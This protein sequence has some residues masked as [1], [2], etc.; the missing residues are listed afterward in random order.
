MLAILVCLFVLGLI[1]GSFISALTWRLHK[2][3]EVGSGQFKD[4]KSRNSE[5]SSRNYSMVNGRSQC[6]HCRHKLEAKDLVP[7][8]SWLW[9]SG[10]CRYCKKAISWQYPAIEVSLAAIFAGSYYFWPGGVDGVG[11]IILLSTW[12]A[13]SIGLM[14]LLVYDARWLL[15][16]NK[17]IYPTLAVA[18]SGRLIYIIGFED[19]KLAAFI[20]WALAVII[21]SGFFWLVYE[22][23]KGRWIG[24]GDVRLGLITGTLLATP[25]KSLLMIFLASIVGTLFILPGLLAKSKKLTS[26]IPYGPFLIIGTYLSFFFGSDI[27]DWYTRLILP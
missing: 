8:F 13:A 25:Q 20:N 3:F 4:K 5:L 21:A 7:L 1:F 19:N 16:P 14:A 24:F 17:L 27:I 11:D 10:R 12:L 23:S 15:L 6:P 26:Q 2:Q 9:L 18:A 22:V